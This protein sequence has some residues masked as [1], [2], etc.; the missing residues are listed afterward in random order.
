MD[1]RTRLLLGLVLVTGVIGLC[2]QY[3]AAYEAEWPYPTGQQLA[4]DYDRHVGETALVFGEV[5]TVDAD[6]GTVVVRVMH[7]PGELAAELAVE[8]VD[9]EALATVRPGGVLQ[10]YGTLE[11]GHR[12]DADEVL[13]THRGPRETLYVT[14]T[15]LVGIA[16][17]VGSVVRYWR[18]TTH[19]LRVEAR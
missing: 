9:A 10:A 11:S 13:V 3:G 17:A 8:G 15:S 5:R 16:V 7:S 1:R 4:T 12:M 19:D 6:E 18:V 2:V 14:V